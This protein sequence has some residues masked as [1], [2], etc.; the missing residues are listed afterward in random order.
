[1]FENVQ[2]LVV[3]SLSY[4]FIVI[5][6]QSINI[7]KQVIIISSE[8]L[9]SISKNYKLNIIEYTFCLPSVVYPKLHMG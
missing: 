5:K 8:T 7:D 9:C 4:S 2:N 1:M 6:S 3:V